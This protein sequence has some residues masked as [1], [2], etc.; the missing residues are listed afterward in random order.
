V[1]PALGPEPLSQ[2]F[3]ADLLRERLGQRAA[4]VKALML[5]QS[6]I[7]GLGNLY[8]DESLFLAGIHPARS[9]S[10]LT[11][12]EVATLRDCIVQALNT[13]CAF[14]DRAREERWPDPPSALQTWT[15]PRKEGEP[16]PR[17]GNAIA[18]MR[19]RARGTFFC[20]H[21]QPHPQG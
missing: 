20:P 3:T 11:V 9:A 18:T 15:V 8:V 4:P 17:C 7:A 16:C 1:L 13:A 12:S 14:Y 2:E 10:D 6:V 21:C 5:E 19:I